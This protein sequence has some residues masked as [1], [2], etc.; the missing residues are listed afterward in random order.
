MQVRSRSEGEAA[1]SGDS[2]GRGSGLERWVHWV[3]QWCGHR[4]RSQAG[5]S[6]SAGSVWCACGVPKD[7]TDSREAA[8]LAEKSWKGREQISDWR[9]SASNS[10]T[11]ERCPGGAA[12]G[13]PLITTNTTREQPAQGK[14]FECAAAAAAGPES[15]TGCRGASL[16]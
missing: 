5:W 11:H 4:A 13:I 9:F 7:C 16:D 10:S 1:L 3:Q 12:G 8:R 14:I 15:E 6:S 2:E